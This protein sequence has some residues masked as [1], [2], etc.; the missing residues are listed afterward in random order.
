MPTF[1]LPFL[2]GGGCWWGKIWVMEV[3]RDVSVESQRILRVCKSRGEVKQNDT[4]GVLE[5]RWE[6][7]MARAQSAR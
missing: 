7:L 1:C 3:F 2:M 6:C 4:C 5:I